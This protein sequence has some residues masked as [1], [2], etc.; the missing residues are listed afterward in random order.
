VNATHAP[1]G[2]GDVVDRREAQQAKGSVPSG[3][4]PQ[5]FFGSS[6]GFFGSMYSR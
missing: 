3:A 5:S 4:R 2:E 1:S 6:A